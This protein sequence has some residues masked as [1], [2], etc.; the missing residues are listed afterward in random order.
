M[1]RD[2]DVKA[3][4]SSA[5]L[6]RSNYEHAV[7]TKVLW[8]LMT[9]MLQQNLSRCYCARFNLVMVDFPALCLSRLDD[10]NSDEYVWRDFNVFVAGQI[11]IGESNSYEWH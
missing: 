8:L 4:F 6:A 3:I 2:V 11:S 1:Y 10:K 5:A 7:R 9:A